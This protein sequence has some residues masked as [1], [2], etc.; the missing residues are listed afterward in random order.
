MVP[1]GRLIIGIGYKY[2]TW[3]VLLFIVTDKT[4]ITQAGPP[5]LSKYTD[6]FSNVAIIPVAPPLIMYKLFGSVNEL[7]SQNK[8]IQSD[9]KLEKL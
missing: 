6:Q 7:D 9:L 1:G 3:K 4:G 2:N 5:Y 8:S